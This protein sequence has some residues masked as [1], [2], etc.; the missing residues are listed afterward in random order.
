MWA[1]MATFRIF[2]ASYTKVTSFFSADHAYYHKQLHILS[3]F[4]A[5]RREFFKISTLVELAS[6]YGVQPT[7][8][9]HWKKEFRERVCEIFSKNTSKNAK[10]AEI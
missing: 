5:L 7:Q 2:E 10:A 4:T 9:T 3:Y 8:I 6:E 1:I